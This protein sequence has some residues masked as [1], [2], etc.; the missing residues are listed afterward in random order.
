[1]GRAMVD[2][3]PPNDQ[4]PIKAY[5]V[6]LILETVVYAVD[7]EKAEQVVTLALS[8]TY[9]SGGGETIVDDGM[10]LRGVPAGMVRLAVLRVMASVPWPKE[11]AAARDWLASFQ[12]KRRSLRRRY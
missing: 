12:R 10:E 4:N 5:H 1:M 8:R 11:D 2:D 3:P 6:S 7:R 9:Q